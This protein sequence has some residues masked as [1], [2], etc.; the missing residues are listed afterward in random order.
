[1]TGTTKRT[2]AE[3]DL[4][5][6]LDGLRDKYEDKTMIMIVFELDLIME[7]NE[8]LEYLSIFTRFPFLCFVN[9]HLFYQLP[10]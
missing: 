4:L 8:E 3:Q 10:F 6:S 7:H 2:Q 9:L 1:M 5:D